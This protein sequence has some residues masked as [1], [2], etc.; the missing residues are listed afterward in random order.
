MQ[1]LP[2]ISHQDLAKHYC[3]NGAEQC[4]LVSIIIPAFNAEE[5]IAK[6]L[7]SVLGQTYRNIEVL[8]VNDGSQDKTPEIVQEYTQRD[9]RIKLLN[10]ANAGVA[11]ARN[12]GI[13]HAKGSLI[14]PIDADD[15]WSYEAV[16]KLVTQLQSS[17]SEVGVV[18]AWSIDIDEQDQPTGGFHAAKIDGNVYKTLIC[19]NFLGNASATLIRKICIEQIGGY[20]IQ[21][22]AQNAQGCEDWDLYIRLAEHYKFAVVPEF[23]IGYRKVSSGM[24]KDFNQMARSQQIMLK[25][26]QNRHPKISSFFYR[27]SLSSFYLYLSHECDGCENAQASLFWLWQAF[28]ID[29][30][31]FLGRPEATILLVKSLI[32]IFLLNKWLIISK[33]DFIE[34]NIV[35][36]NPLPTSRLF[37]SF[38]SIESIK[39][40]RMKIQFKVF[41]ASLL[42]Q[43][44]SRV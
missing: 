14:A 34:P 23:L 35:E 17:C 37:N 41:M 11:A 22:R 3:S 5:F 25:K 30:I 40:S 1:A 21:F 12:L 10:Q 44:V 9:V 16:A 24:S 33:K 27:L 15:L 29:A 8:V 7:E 39:T 4:P 18:Y 28:K 26:V 31:V 13:Q 20:D 43:S 32:Q 38:M 6:T 42:H 36:E 19:H 2:L